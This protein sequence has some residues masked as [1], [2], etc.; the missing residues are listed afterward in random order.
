MIVNCSLI[1]EFY[2]VLHIGITLSQH[3]Q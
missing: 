3:N 2:I 1:L